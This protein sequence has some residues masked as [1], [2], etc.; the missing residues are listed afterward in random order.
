MSVNSSVAATGRPVNQITNLVGNAEQV[1]I[2]TP[3][4]GKSYTFTLKN[5]KTQTCL[6]IPGSSKDTGI[7]AI[8]WPC[9]GGLSDQMWIIRDNN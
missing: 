5:V 1:W 4:S 8:V 6:A 9:I 3:V 7:H 2:K